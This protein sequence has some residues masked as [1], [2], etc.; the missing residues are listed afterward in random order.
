[1]SCPLHKFYV[2]LFSKCFKSAIINGI[3]GGNLE[4]FP[5]GKTWNYFLCMH[6]FEF[7]PTLYVYEFLIIFLLF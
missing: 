3:F 6:Q 5:Y 1:M 4:F 7:Y 2:I